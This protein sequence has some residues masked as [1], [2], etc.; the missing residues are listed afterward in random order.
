MQLPFALKIILWKIVDLVQWHSKKTFVINTLW[1]KTHLFH[2]HFHQKI[3]DSNNLI[4]DFMIWTALYQ[5]YSRNSS[6]LCSFQWQQFAEV[7]RQCT[8]FFLFLEPFRMYWCYC[9]NANKTCFF[10]SF[11]EILKSLTL[12]ILQSLI[13]LWGHC[14]EVVS[15]C[16]SIA[17]IS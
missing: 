5:N 17:L 12:L 14:G 7:N 2:E 1:L 10:F 11:R 6:L 8:N 9:S 16:R 3:S 13:A 4:Y 15:W